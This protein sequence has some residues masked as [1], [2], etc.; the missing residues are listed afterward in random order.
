MHPRRLD[1][2]KTGRRKEIAV[3]AILAGS[4][5]MGFIA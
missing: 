5:P 4:S 2:W 3:T 1:E